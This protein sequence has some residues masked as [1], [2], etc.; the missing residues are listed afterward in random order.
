MKA[1]HYI[2]GLV[3]LVSSC[4]TKVN[5]NDLAISNPI[6]AQIDLVEVVDDKV[7]VTIDPG[8]F[9]EETIVY[10]LPKVV[11]GT[12]AVSDFGNFI[13]SFQALDY[14]GEPIT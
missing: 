5:I 7:T 13:E 11:Q 3:I 9:T 1:Y 12:Y 4:G 14:E 10:R 6:A 2:L 8:R